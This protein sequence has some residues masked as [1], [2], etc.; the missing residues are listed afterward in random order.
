MLKSSLQVVDFAR[1]GLAPSANI[2][3]SALV[4]REV[5]TLQRQEA[6]MDS[7][8]SYSHMLRS[9]SSLKLTGRFH[10]AVF[11]EQALRTLIV[12]KTVYVTP[13][14]PP[15]ASSSWTL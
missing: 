11:H 13:V 8:T 10:G 9:L 15:T 3:P 7:C 5:L 1:V 6:G 12:G 14:A 4:T 2:A